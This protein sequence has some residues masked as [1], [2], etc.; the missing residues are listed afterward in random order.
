MYVPMSLK[1]CF[2]GY[3]SILKQ[4]FVTDFNV[5]FEA[6]SSWKFAP[7]QNLFVE[8]VTIG[9]C[10]GASTYVANRVTRCVCVKVAH[11]EAQPIF[12]KINT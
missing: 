2:F 9:D 8:K 11:N 5:Y 6:I 12:V 1:A 10:S 3:S 4:N 7:R